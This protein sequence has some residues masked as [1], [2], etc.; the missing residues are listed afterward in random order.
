M[1]ASISSIRDTVLWF[2]WLGGREGEREGVPSLIKSAVGLLLSSLFRPALLYTFPDFGV[3]VIILFIAS[4]SF[5]SFLFCLPISLSVTL[6]PSLTLSLFSPS[7]SLP[8]S[9]SLSLSRSLSPPSF[10]LSLYTCT[11]TVLWHWVDLVGS[12]WRQ[13]FEG[14]RQWDDSGRIH[15][16]LQDSAQAGHQ[17]ALLWC[18]HPLLLLHAKDKGRSKDGHAV[19]HVTVMW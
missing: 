19:S 14:W 9:L 1:R 7:L 2:Q 15:R 8:L 11:N 17:H 4:Y 13:G 12:F 10:S 18:L 16:V 6:S 3:G 5:L